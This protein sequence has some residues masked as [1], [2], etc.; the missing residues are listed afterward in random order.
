M[1]SEIRHAFDRAKDWDRIVY[2]PPA[3]HIHVA[4]AMSNRGELEVDCGW[5]EGA[6]I[7]TEL[8]T[9]SVE[10]APMFSPFT[11]RGFENHRAVSSLNV[12]WVQESDPFGGNSALRVRTLFVIHSVLKFLSK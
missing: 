10:I 5:V 1:A 2:R 9:S 6:Q 7:I 4:V 3:V 8:F 12:S 11:N